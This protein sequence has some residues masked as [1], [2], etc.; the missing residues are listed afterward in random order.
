MGGVGADFVL[1]PLIYNHLEFI[2][3]LDVVARSQGVECRLKYDIFS[4][5][6]MVGE[7]ES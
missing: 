5:T 2:L 6:K 4:P 3:T 1:N 7:L